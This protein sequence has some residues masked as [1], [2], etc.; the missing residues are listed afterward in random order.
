MSATRFLVATLTVVL[1]IWLGTWVLTVYFLSAW[2]ERGQFGDLFGSVN[3]LFS[4]LAFAGLL[5]TVRL[6][7]EQLSTQRK[8]FGAQLKELKLQSEELISSRKELARQASAQH[9]LYRATV[10]QIA[11]AAA[12]AR[13]ESIKLDSESVVP[14]G[15]DSFK[16]QIDAVVAGLEALSDRMEAESRSA[17]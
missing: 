1:L 4:G 10:A 2:P 12:N 16:K 14:S 3:A 6:Q 11:V 17:G 9:A 8:E 15:R 7:Q 5:F 13:I